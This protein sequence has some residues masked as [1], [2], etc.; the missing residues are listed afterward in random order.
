MG[1]SSLL[2]EMIVSIHFSL[3]IGNHFHGKIE[4]TDEPILIQSLPVY[5]LTS[6]LLHETGHT[7]SSRPSQG[8]RVIVMS[9]V[10]IRVRL[11][12]PESVLS[13]INSHLLISIHSVRM[14]KP[15]SYRTWI[16]LVSLIHSRERRCSSSSERGRILLSSEC[17]SRK[18]RLSR[19]R[20]REWRPSHMMI[21]VS[22]HS[23]SRLHSLER[24]PR[25]SAIVW[26]FR[27]VHRVTTSSHGIASPDS[28]IQR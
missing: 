27:T 4:M 6:L 11:S 8:I 7:L 10:S 3:T 9:S 21:R 12:L 19:V 15:R 26:R 17:T 14:M 20:Q 28:K 1:R 24:H 2:L 5:Q 22:S 18:V 25:S 13:R 23:P 16:L